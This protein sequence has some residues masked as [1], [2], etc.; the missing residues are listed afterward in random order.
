MNL[1]IKGL[2]YLLS[3]LS[4]ALMSVL[5]LAVLF[6]VFMRYVAGAPVTFTEE[7]SR[8]LLIWLGL[9]AAAYA[10]RLRM[11][12]ALDL[13][14]LKLNERQ[15]VKL[16]VVIHTLIALFALSVLVYGGIQ[17]VILTYVLD[18]YSPALGVSMSVVYLALPLSGIAMVLYAVEFILQ[19]LG[20]RRK[21]V[22][23]E[24]AT[25]EEDVLAG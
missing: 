1:L 3:R 6:Q 22:E 10:Y 19:E 13:L 4:V 11:H 5:V 2:D 20:I 16:N 8:Y 12:L 7:L 9:M 23:P 15:R 25:E 18:Q 21:E 17:L 14:V 24:H